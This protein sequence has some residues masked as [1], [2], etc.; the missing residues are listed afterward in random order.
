MAKSSGQC[1]CSLPLLSSSPA[2]E[3]LVEAMVDEVGKEVGQ[4]RK[5][6]IRW[7]DKRV[8]TRWAWSEVRTGE[9]LS[10]ETV[11]VCVL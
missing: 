7:K 5:G 4:G 1:S 11:C 3:K 2:K 10:S 8:D 9:G 6:K